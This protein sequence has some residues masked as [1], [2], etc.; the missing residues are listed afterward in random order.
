MDIE[1]EIKKNPNPFLLTTLQRLKI[2]RDYELE[3]SVKNLDSFPQ[4]RESEV[5]GGFRGLGVP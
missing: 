3:R 5:N 1:M 4:D 2:Y